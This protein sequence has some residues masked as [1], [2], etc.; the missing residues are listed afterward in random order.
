[1]PT[2]PEHALL[3]R[4]VYPVSIVWKNFL[5]THEVGIQSINLVLLLPLDSG[6]SPETLFV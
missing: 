5:L 6:R 1:M 3:L 2:T 4:A